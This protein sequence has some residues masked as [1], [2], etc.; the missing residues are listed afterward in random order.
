M[1]LPTDDFV[2]VLT[3]SFHHLLCEPWPACLAL[4]TIPFLGLLAGKIGMPGHAAVCQA[5]VPH[6][7][8]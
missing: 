5:V 1:S 7:Q 3:N 4:V 2:G 6:P 8:A